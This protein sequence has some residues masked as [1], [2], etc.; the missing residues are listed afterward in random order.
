MDFIEIEPSFER[1]LDISA[2][3]IKRLCYIDQFRSLSK[4]YIVTFVGNLF[5]Q[6]VNMHTKDPRLHENKKHDLYAQ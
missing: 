5:H 4:H 3:F 1:L 2:I 6:R